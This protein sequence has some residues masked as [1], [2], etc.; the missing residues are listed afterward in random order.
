MFTV[1]A[2][3][4][5]QRLIGVLRMTKDVHLPPPAGADEVM[6]KLAFY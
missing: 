3:R 4:I 2:S 1:T 5:R 6:L